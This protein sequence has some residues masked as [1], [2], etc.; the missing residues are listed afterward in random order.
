MKW[1][2]S[3]KTAPP[4]LVKILL[5]YVIMDMQCTSFQSYFLHKGNYGLSYLYA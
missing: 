2:T 3:S 4:K 1:D 5:V